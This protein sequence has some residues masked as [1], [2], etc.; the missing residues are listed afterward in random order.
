MAMQPTA[1]GV[2]D[3]SITILSISK[4]SKKFEPKSAGSA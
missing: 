1:I 4:I 3:L 2:W